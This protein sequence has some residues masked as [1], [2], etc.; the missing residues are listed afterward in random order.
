LLS[1]FVVVNERIACALVVAGVLT[2]R[3]RDTAVTAL[4]RPARYTW[5]VAVPEPV[6]TFCMATLPPNPESWT[7]TSV[8]AMLVP[9]NAGKGL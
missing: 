6:A 7:P 2:G 3:L 4:P 1:A 9:V 5:F 8:I